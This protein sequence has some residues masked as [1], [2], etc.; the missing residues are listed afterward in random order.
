VNGVYLRGALAIHPFNPSK[1]VWQATL[2]A[3]ETPSTPRQ[4]KTQ[5]RLGPSDLPGCI[6]SNH[7]D[8]RKAVEIACVSSDFNDV[9][10]AGLEARGA[11]VER[12]KGAEPSPRSERERSRAICREIGG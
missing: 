12:N 3:A 10:I 5:R 2:Q 6:E 8:N 9:V 4:P 7:L 11:I 1:K